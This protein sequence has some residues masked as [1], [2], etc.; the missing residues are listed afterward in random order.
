MKTM[1]MS[2]LALTALVIGFASCKKDDNDEKVTP[3][4]TKTDSIRV[5]A[6]ARSGHY[7]FYSFKEGKEID[8]KDSASTKW[9]IGIR[10]ATIITNSG[11]SGPGTVGAITEKGQFDTYM[12]APETGYAY[13]TTAS[14]LAIN[15]GMNNGWFNYDPATH[16]FSPKAGMFFVIKT[17][18]NKYVKV[19]MLSARYEEFV[20]PMPQYVWHKFRYVYQ[21]DGSRDLK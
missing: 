2:L 20:G 12:M 7:S 19:E 17:S 11:E 15:S 13:D 6:N 8:L 16:N 1:K 4:V 10:L 3:V 18:D 21:P 14:K 5:T 9:D